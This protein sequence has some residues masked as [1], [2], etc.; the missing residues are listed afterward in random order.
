MCDSDGKHK[1]KR[2]HRFEDMNPVYWTLTW[3]LRIATVVLLSLLISFVIEGLQLPETRDY[4][5]KSNAATECYP[6]IFTRAQGRHLK[7]K[8]AAANLENLVRQYDRA[9]EQCL[10][11]WFQPR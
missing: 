10:K 7:I 2:E 8:N 1:R 9:N 5:R 3:I 11:K 4:G 6:G